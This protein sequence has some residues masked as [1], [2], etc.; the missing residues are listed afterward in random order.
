MAIMAHVS[1]ITSGRLHLQRERLDLR[2]VVSHAIETLESD[3]AERHHRLSTALPDTPLWLEGRPRNRRC[4]AAFS[5]RE[6][7]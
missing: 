4:D 1:R 3:L 5:P 7:R 6:S 2:D